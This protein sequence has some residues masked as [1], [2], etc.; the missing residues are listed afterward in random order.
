MR[1]AATLS[2]LARHVRAGPTAVAVLARAAGSTPREA[3]AWMLVTPA[4][5]AGT[6]GGGEA[7]RRAIEAARALL[8][9]E[10]ART[11]LDIPLGPE[12]DQCCGGRMAVV[13]VRI[14][15]PPA[16]P[17]ALWE[18]GPLIA[19]PPRQPVLV[20]GAGHVG[21]A[22]VAAL[23]PLPFAIDWIDPRAEALWPV[24]GAVPCRR[25]AL[26]EAAAAAAPDDAIHLVMTHSHAV[27]L[28]IVATVLARPFA[29]LGLIGSATKRATFV[30]RL[31]E[32]GLDATRLTCPI[33]LDTI[34]GKEPAVIAASVA[35]QLLILQRAG[36][37]R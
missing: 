36:G 6:I 20:Y 35:A 32:R 25:L 33:G 7:E 16:G 4:E 15:T 34:P 28:E 10:A 30:R 18:G 26:P 21:A 27:D 5:T 12:I 19:D 1:A 14:A 22:L 11:D 3:G 23:A 31:A 17:F 9:G 29:F 2:D 24:A 13:I 8:A 37:P